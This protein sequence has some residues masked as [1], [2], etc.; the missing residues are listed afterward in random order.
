[1]RVKRGQ[2]EQSPVDVNGL[3]IVGVALILGRTYRLDDFNDVVKQKEARGVVISYA[4]WQRQFNGAPYVIGRTLRV[5]AEPRTVIGVMPNG[6]LVVALAGRHRVLGCHGSSAHPGSSLADRD[7][8]A[9]ARSV[10]AGGR[11]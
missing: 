6:F 4:T 11:G 5:D 9:E 10:N 3:S 1:M 8:T 7:W 2:S